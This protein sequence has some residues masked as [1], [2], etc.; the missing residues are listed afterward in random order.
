MYGEG[1]IIN[2]NVEWSGTTGVAVLNLPTNTRLLILAIVATGPSGS[3]GERCL[4]QS[5]LD[6]RQGREYIVG[7][8]QAGGVPFRMIGHCGR[9][10]AAS[11]PR[12]VA[13]AATLAERL[14]MEAQLGRTSPA[15]L[16]AAIA[17]MFGESSLPP[18]AGIVAFG[19]TMRLTL[20]SQ[21]S[22][23]PTQIAMIAVEMAAIERGYGIDSL[24]ASPLWFAHTPLEVTSGAAAIAFS[25]ELQFPSNL[26]R[27]TEE[28]VHLTSRLIPFNS[29]TGALLESELYLYNL[30]GQK[31]N[32]GEPYFYG[33]Q[34]NADAW[35]TGDAL[36][37]V[38]YQE[39]QQL[40]FAGSKGTTTAS[41]LFLSHQL[42]IADLQA[43]TLMHA[44]GA[45][46]RA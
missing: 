21:A 26:L 3:T 9:F 2:A 1:T 30:G 46:R 13:P 4:V 24:L 27:E 18:V 32:S 28:A 20:T 29:D 19:G 38:T 39:G 40:Q 33:G 35:A 42:T 37:E 36:F 17:R 8:P 15:P 11:G 43:T 41:N 22:D 44:I 7:R 23:Q 16:A 14:R 6:V 31:P 5:L 12:W 45:A 34:P 10:D 25:D